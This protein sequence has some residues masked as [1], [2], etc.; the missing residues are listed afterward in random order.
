MTATQTQYIHNVTLSAERGVP[1]GQTHGI[2]PWN[3][4][5]LPVIL[6]NFLLC[7]FM[8]IEC[9]AWG[10]TLEN[11]CSVTLYMITALFLCRI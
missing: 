4:D 11:R 2:L 5:A 6:N 1:A 8:K 3:S 10:V 9:G 7:E